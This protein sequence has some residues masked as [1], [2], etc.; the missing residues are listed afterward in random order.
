M[1]DGSSPRLSRCLREVQFEL[2]VLT[3]TKRMFGRCTASQITAASAASF[4]PRLPLMRY[5]V[6]NLGAISLTVW[7]WAAN[8]RAH[9][10]APVQAS[11]PIVHAGSAATS[12]LNVYVAGLPAL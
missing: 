2:S 12:S 3:G 7:P 4:L 6:T 10:C 8:C 9:W 11:M 1:D 5:G